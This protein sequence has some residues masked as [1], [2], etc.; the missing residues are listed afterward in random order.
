VRPKNEEK[1][2]GGGGGSGERD[3]IT[4]GDHHVDSKR[5]KNKT[6]T[7]GRK[8]ERKLSASNRTKKWL[9]KKGEKKLWPT[10]LGTPNAQQSPIKRV[11][12]GKYSCQMPVGGPWRKKNQND[13]SSTSNSR[14]GETPEGSGKNGKGGESRS[15]GDQVYSGVSK[16]PCRIFRN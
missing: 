15:H 2:R 5:D 8:R 16:S 14:E 13:L 1:I 9:K 10:I 6:T 12:K 4:S 7:G 3:G 11:G